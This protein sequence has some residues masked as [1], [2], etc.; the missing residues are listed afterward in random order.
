MKLQT[1]IAASLLL[2]ATAGSAS[3]AATISTEGKAGDTVSFSGQIAPGEDLYI[4]V[5]M[6]D[7]FKPADSALPHEKK[8]FASLVKKKGFNKDTLLPPLF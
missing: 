5:A 4:T 6:R 3:A 7:Q 2:F 8:K 1:F